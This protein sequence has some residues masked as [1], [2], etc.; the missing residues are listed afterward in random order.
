MGFE[1]LEDSAA[2]ID[3]FLG[4][5]CGDY[6]WDDFLSRPNPD[7]LIRAV[8]DYCADTHFRYP[9]TMDG[10]WCSENGVSNLAQLA[11][12]L[13]SGART[14]VEEFLKGEH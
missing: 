8:K 1:S 7:P 10:H 11:A 3:S 2:V 14:A 12:I 13:R 9:P 6:D 4:D 5:C